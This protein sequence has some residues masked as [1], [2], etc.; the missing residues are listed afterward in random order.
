MLNPR[1]KEIVDKQAERLGI[2]KTQAMHAYRA[3]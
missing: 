1:V 3:Y 2:D